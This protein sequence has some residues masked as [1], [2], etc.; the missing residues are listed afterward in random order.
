MRSLLRIVLLVTVVLVLPLMTVALWSGPM[1]DWLEAWR[2]SPPPAP[3]LATA[4]VLLLASDILLPVPSGPLITIAGSQLGVVLTAAAAWLGLMLGG[5]VA[6]TLAKCWGR[7]LAE[8]FA[9]ASELA[10]LRKIADQHDVWL[11]LVTRPLPVLAEATVLLAGV[12]DTRWRRLLWTLG[13]GNAVVAVA[14]A[15][16]GQQ[17]EQNEWLAIAV[18]LS[19]ALPLAAA[20]AFRRRFQ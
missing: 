5:V 6:F 14:F 19:I 4:L 1:E 11:L 2:E 10:S 8:R 17:A 12:L 20:W 16:L 7:P 9:A 15:V 13:I 18:V 3:L